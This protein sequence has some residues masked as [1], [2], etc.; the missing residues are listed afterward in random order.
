MELGKKIC[1]RLTQ[2]QGE[3][4]K[5]EHVWRVCFEVTHPERMEG[6]GGSGTDASSSQQKK[7]ELLDNTATD[8]V[9]LL[10]SNVMGGMTPANAVW[11][12][13]DVSEETDDERRWLDDAAQEVWQ[14]IHQSNYDSQK[15]EALVDSLIAGWM[16]L[17]IEEEEGRP[18]FFQYSLGQCYIACSKL[19]GQVDTLYRC[20]SMTAEQAV[21]EYG[22]KVSK[23]IQDDAADPGRSST[24]HEFV[25]AVYPRTNSS[26]MARM[27][28]NLPFASCHV[29]ASTQE[30]VRESGYHE[31]PFSCPRWMVLPNSAYAIGLVSNALGNIR[32][33]NELLRLEK[34]A[35]GRAAAGTYIGVDDGVL[36][37]RNV[38]VRGGTVI[39]AN[40]VDSLKELPTGADFN[41]TFSKADHMRAEIRR[42]LLADQLQPQDKPQMTATEVHVRVALIR[43]LLGPLYGRF[44]SEDLSITI[45]RV[46]GMMY[47]F[48]RPDLGGPPG[49]LLIPDA[50]E[51][52]AG[53]IYSIRYLSPLARAQKLEDVTAIERVTMLAGQMAQLGKPET[54]D[55]IDGD[56]SIRISAEALGAPSKMLRDE[57]ALVA[58]RKAKAEEQ[59]RAQQQAQAQQMQTMAVDTM[60][61]RSANAPA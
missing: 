10:A 9:R 27:A 52:L 21:N 42:L 34:I 39:V 33:L 50:P 28:K 29:E 53:E 18:V 47:R 11:L 23:K 1:T 60:M 48:G 51:S 17:F 20:F 35:L 55:L 31:Q 3:R 37:P 45:E 19:G 7:C 61:Q 41:V 32:E 13:F 6:L 36:N 43:Q 5:S 14:A 4:S 40:S 44:Q 12:G 2:M 56:Q 46:F 38:R 26:K 49:P 30:V 58:Y 25:H 57:K 54:L 22:T 15:Y 16:V 24:M 59:Q 8:G